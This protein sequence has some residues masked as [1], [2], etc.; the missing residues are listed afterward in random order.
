MFPA[1]MGLEEKIIFSKKEIF[2]SYNICWDFLSLAFL[3]GDKTES[4]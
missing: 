4:F 2:L 3:F 1:L